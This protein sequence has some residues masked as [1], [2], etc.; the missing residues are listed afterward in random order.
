MYIKLFLR[1]SGLFLPLTRSI[2]SLRS[3][4][5]RVHDLPTFRKVRP[6]PLFLYRRRF[7]RC[8]FLYRRART[9]SQCITVFCWGRCGSRSWNRCLG[10]CRLLL[11][12]L[13]RWDSRQPICDGCKVG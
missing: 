4:L 6:A 5:A 9:S 7:R 12:L 8:R 11:L 3:N 1:T 2:Y 10:L 13:P